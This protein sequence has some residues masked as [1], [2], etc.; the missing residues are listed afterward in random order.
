MFKV[1]SKSVS[2]NTSEKK[3]NVGKKIKPLVKNS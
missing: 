3:N 1:V 2:N